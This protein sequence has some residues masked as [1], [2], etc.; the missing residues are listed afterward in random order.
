MSYPSCSYM[1]YGPF[2]SVGLL[3][4]RSLLT[5]HYT[6]GHLIIFCYHWPDLS[7]NLWWCINKQYPFFF[8]HKG[9]IFKLQFFLADLT[10][11]KV[12][13]KHT[14]PQKLMH[15]IITLKYLYFQLLWTVV[16]NKTKCKPCLSDIGGTV[17]HALKTTCI[18]RPP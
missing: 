12:K 11:L 13:V 18:Q 7:I 4:F 1:K 14:K 9:H 15:S 2:W 16:R 10:N 6:V 8:T 5:P 3:W 17:K